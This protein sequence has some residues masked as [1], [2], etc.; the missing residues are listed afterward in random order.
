MKVD[1]RP[2]TCFLSPTIFK[3]GSMGW[4]LSLFWGYVTCVMVTLQNYIESGM[5]IN[6]CQGQNPLKHVFPTLDGLMV[7]ADHSF[8]MVKTWKYGT[9]VFFFFFFFFQFCGLVTLVFGFNQPKLAIPAR[10]KSRKNYESCYILEIFFQNPL[11]KF[12]EKN[13]ILFFGCNFGAFFFFG[14]KNPLNEMQWIIFCH[15]NVRIHSQKIKHWLEHCKGKIKLKG[16]VLNTLSL[17]LSLS[18]LVRFIFSGSWVGF[19]VQGLGL[20]E[21]LNSAHW[22]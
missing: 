18:H 22:M 2:A 3:P 17:S 9:R 4:H 15:R 20:W 8:K 21:K 11:F 1:W 16:T 19:R 13:L 10:E 12:G 7:Q 6:R 5:D 14:Y